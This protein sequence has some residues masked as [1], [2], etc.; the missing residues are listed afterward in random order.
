ME[1]IPA[2]HLKFSFVKINSEKYLV[3]IF[4][5]HDNF[6]QY[7]YTENGNS[8]LMFNR[9][10]KRIISYAEFKNWFNQSLFR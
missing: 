8:Y 5:K 10:R 1:Y 6:A 9:S 3:I 2:Y 4:V 7:T